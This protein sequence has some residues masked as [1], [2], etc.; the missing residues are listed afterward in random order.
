MFQSKMHRKRNAFPSTYQSILERLLQ[1]PMNLI[2]HILNTA[3]APDNQRLAEIG[4]HAPPLRVDAHEAQLVPAA[5]DDVLNAEVELAR[6]HG[7][8]GLAGE[9][10]EVLEGDGVDFVVDVEAGG[11]SVGMMVVVEVRRW[12]VV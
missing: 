9:S 4:I 6:H 2:T 3:I 8:V 7:G 10:V 1:R 11:R 12:E 5:L